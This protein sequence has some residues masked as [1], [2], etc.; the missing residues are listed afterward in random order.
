[1]LRTLPTH[2]VRLLVAGSVLQL[3]L[4]VTTTSEAAVQERLHLTA[5]TLRVTGTALHSG[6][7]PVRVLVFAVPD[8]TYREWLSRIAAS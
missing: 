6:R 4:V 2:A 1:M 3:T 5:S 8:Q 7:R